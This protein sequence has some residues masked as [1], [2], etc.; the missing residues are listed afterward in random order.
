MIP[1]MN[2]KIL[3]DF[4]QSPSRKTSENFAAHGIIIPPSATGE[5]RAVCPKCGKN[6]RKKNLAVNVAKGVWRCHRC[7]WRGRLGHDADHHRHDPAELQRQIDAENRQRK[8]DG[9]R[10]ADR[11]QALWK[12]C[13]PTGSHPYL[14]RKGIGAH[15]LRFGVDRNGAF[16]VVPMR[17]KTG[18]LVGAQR[19]YAHP[20]PE[21]KTDKVFGAGT[22]KQG[23]FHVIGDPDGAPIIAIGEGYSTCASVHEATGWPVIVAFDAGNVIHVARIWRERYPAAALI[24]AAD[25]D[26]WKPERGNPGLRHAYE[27]AARIG[28]VRVAYPAFAPD[29]PGKPTDFNDL[30]AL[31]GLEAVKARL[32]EAMR[33]EPQPPIDEDLAARC[34]CGTE[35]EPADPTPDLAALPAVHADDATAT[36]AETRA[37]LRATVHQFFDGL[38]SDRSKSLAIQAPAGIGKTVIVAQEATRHRALLGNVFVPSHRL[39]AEQAARYPEGHAVVIRGRT[40]AADGLPPLCPKAAAVEILQRAGHARDVRGLLCGVRTEGTEVTVGCAEFG[41][42]RCR[43]YEQFRDPAPIRIYS[44]EWLTKNPSDG[45]KVVG[46]REPDYNVIDENFSATA[47]SKRAWTSERIIADTLPGSIWRAALSAALEGTV[48]ALA[49]RL[50][51]IDAELD[52]DQP[53]TIPV[54]PAMT[55]AETERALECW[56]PQRRPVGFLR[57]VRAVATGAAKPAQLWVST[58]GDKTRV[59]FASVA[60]LPFLAGKPTLAI[61]ATPN[62]DLIAQTLGADIH[63]LPC[64]RN[65]RIVQIVDRTLSHS[66]VI[67][68]GRTDAD[69]NPIPDTSAEKLGHRLV[70]FAWRQFRLNPAGAVI[71]PKQWIDRWR[72]HL[73]P[74]PLGWYGALRGLNAMERAEWLVQISWNMPSADAV[75]SQ[76]RA[77]HPDSAA[78]LVGKYE[79]QTVRVEARDGTTAAV[80][81]WIHRDPNAQKILEGIREAEAVQALDR[82]RLLNDGPKKTVFLLCNLPLPD[83]RPDHLVKLNDLL[84]PAQLAQVM[85][86]DGII[87]CDRSRLARRHPDLF[88]SPNHA[89]AAVQEWRQNLMVGNAISTYIAKSTINSEPA[90]TLSLR[91]ISYRVAGSRGKASVGIVG[92]GTDPAAALGK[93]YE[94]PVTVLG[95]ATLADHLAG[96]AHAPPPT[97]TPDPVPEP[98]PAVSTPPPTPPVAVPDTVAPVPLHARIVGALKSTAST[99]GQTEIGIR[100][101]SAAAL[102]GGVL[103]DLCRR[104]VIARSGGGFRPVGVAP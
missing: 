62:S 37:A 95:T 27:A 59:H 6:H 4:P 78:K 3:P 70:E 63:A 13:R 65:A 9:R 93:I 50:A 32:V 84:L 76:T 98:A 100:V 71:A 15:G 1:K 87:P 85:T 2:S 28:G 46:R 101:G 18:E 23:A 75:E 86:R 43:Y 11:A 80:D 49:G 54:R 73:P 40:H 30:H 33:P 47:V 34:G 103:H 14:D 74:V 36:P 7:D 69:G 29:A 79:R 38:R 82:L 39:G 58:V 66:S 89:W 61:D 92:E 88:D 51:E 94:R 72:D 12:R 45:L 31:M 57:A 24:V 26:K 104:G 96:K 90:K 8:E 25:N 56:A 44:H 81:R 64:R 52:Q 99:L 21:I 97:P 10:A 48:P 5:T 35:P 17:D 91:V 22:E 68:D 55:A 42:G 53:D 83:A 41:A 20:L 77:I 60:P 16:A 67:G 102:L 19:I